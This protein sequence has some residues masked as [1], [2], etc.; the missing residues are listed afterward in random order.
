MPLYSSSD[1]E[2]YLSGELSDPE[3]H[4]M[5]RA[6]LDDP[7]LADALEGMVLHRSLPEQPV[8]RQDMEDLQKRL[9]DRVSRKE[10]RPRL[11][12]LAVRYAAAVILLLGIG[13]T[14]YYTLFSKKMEQPPLAKNDV[15]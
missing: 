6:A 11:L 13:F 1:I 8:F 2:K 3:M 9:D 10:S 5:E 7:F 4:A 12:P 14:A 15:E